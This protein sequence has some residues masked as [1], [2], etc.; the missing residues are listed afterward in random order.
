MN[1]NKIRE[2]FPIL[3]NPKKP[4]IY[5]DNACMT[6]RPRQVIEKMDEYYYEYPAC[7]ERSHH[8]LGK[9]A[10]EE[11]S[12]S[13]DIIRKFINA[14]SDKEIIFTRNTTEGIN[15]LA[16]TFGFH[17]DDYILSTDKEH[18]SN[19]LPWQMI[20]RD[21]GLHR[22]RISTKNG[23]DMTSFEQILKKAKGSNNKIFISMAQT[24]NLDGTNV[25]LKEII[26]TAHD[27]D[28]IVMLDGAQSVPHTPI[29]V[30]KLDVDFLVFSG[31]KMLG[32]SGTG[33]VYGKEELLKRLSMFNIGG[34]TVD[35]STYDDA[36]FAQLPERFEAGL[37][38][39]GGFIG[40]G[41]AAEY[42]KRYIDDIH[43]HEIRLNKIVTEGLK[44]HVN[45]LGPEDPKLRSGIFSFNAKNGMDF[46]EIALMLDSYANIM[47]RS[48]RHCVHSW[49][50]ANNIDG[51]ARASF[52]LYNTEDEAK[53][54]VEKA[55]EIFKMK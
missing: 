18:N 9:K 43:E 39:Y 4:V 51:S 1:I 25:P 23:F 10:T 38:D 48:G 55:K 24:S 11:Y 33:I 36:T 50:N 14:K 41:A 40:L 32:P 52:Y 30:K 37:Q 12:R 6:L 35:D 19:L 29:D 26:N 44:H 49:F 54:F 15:L 28:A 5:F 21:K 47:I 3:N 42:L 34:E 8:R 53:I 46:H 16:K 13:R 7:A 31:H 20:A 45:I 22:E 2:D 27:Y 17:R